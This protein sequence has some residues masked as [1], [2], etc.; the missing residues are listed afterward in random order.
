MC[1]HRDFIKMWLWFLM[2]TWSKFWHSI[3]VASQITEKPS[4]NT[5]RCCILQQ[6]SFYMHR[7]YYKKR[8]GIIRARIELNKS[9][10]GN[11]HVS[12][13]LLVSLCQDQ[14]CRVPGFSGSWVVVWIQTGDSSLFCTRWGS[15]AETS[16]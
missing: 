10:V 13:A 5:Q 4:D 2:L 16:A 3:N 11:K 8:R 7:Q 14:G 1:V 15:T 9:W 12:Q 6:T